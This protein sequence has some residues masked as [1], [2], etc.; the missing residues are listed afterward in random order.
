MK[1]RHYISTLCFALAK[2]PLGRTSIIRRWLLEKAGIRI[3]GK[4]HFIARSVHFDSVY[5]QNIILHNDVHITQNVQ[6]LTHLLDTANPDR[7]DIH[8]KEGHVEIEEGA[9]IGC[10]TI[11]SGVIKIGKG[12]IIGAGSVL[13]RSVPPYEIWGGNPARK[14]KTRA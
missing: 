1:I 14:I 5:P 10:G 7:D 6:I 13:T 8:W 3:D 4:R 2:L 11:I 12:A 9:F